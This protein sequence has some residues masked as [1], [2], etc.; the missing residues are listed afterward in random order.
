MNKLQFY[1]LMFMPY[2]FIPPADDLPSTWVNL[3]NTLYDPKVGHRLYNEY[4]ELN[5]LTEKLG[6]DGVLVNEHHQTAYGTM[7]SPNIMASYIVAKTERIKVGV[8]GNALPLHG[9]P[10]RVAEEI[11][12]LDVISGGRIISGF[13]RGT[14]MEYH[15]LRANPAT[16]NPV[17]APS[18]TIGASAEPRSTGPRGLNASDASI[19]QARAWAAKSLISRTASNSKCARRS[20]SETCQS[21]LVNSISPSRTGPATATTARGGRLLRPIVR[22]R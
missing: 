15:S 1:S 12:M 18:T 19:G 3:P 10:M 20:P 16:P 17:P 7:P 14:G 13:V 8:I 11:A 2:P 21:R 9:N 4:L 6:Y 5:V 22:S